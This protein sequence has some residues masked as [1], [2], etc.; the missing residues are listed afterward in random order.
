[1]ILEGSFGEVSEKAKEPLSRI[2][3]S[4]KLMAVSIED[5]LN[6]S[7]IEQGRMKYDMTDFDLKDLA[8]TVFEELKSTAEAKKLAFTF[9][10]DNSAPY[11]VHADIGKIK[12]VI[13]NLADNSIKYTP[14]GSVEISVSHTSEKKIRVAIKDSGVGISEETKSKLFDKFVR[15]RNAHEVNVTGTGLGLY[16]AKQMIEAHNGKIWVESPGE[17]RGST[18]FIELSQKV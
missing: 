6:V 18:F 14:E 16:V 5:F 2:Y 8:K 15:A 9:T 1:M 12:Q 4:S 3:E 17:G 7:R 13:S 11:I 10:D